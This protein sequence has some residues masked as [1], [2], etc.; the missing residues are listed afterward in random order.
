MD[1][2]NNGSRVRGTRKRAISSEIMA[3]WHLVR[4]GIGAASD[5]ARIDSISNII[6]RARLGAARMARSTSA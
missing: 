6:V 4:G 5:N 2:M 3:S 1:Q